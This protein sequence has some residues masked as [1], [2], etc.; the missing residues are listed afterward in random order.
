MKMKAN[1][2]AM[3]GWLNIFKEKGYISSHV[4]REI[5]KK[6]NIKKIGHYGT[7]DPLASGVLPLALGEATKTIK[8]ITYD[9]KEY[10]FFINWGK[11]T[12][13]C[14]KEGKVIQETNIRPKID[15]IKLTI[16]KYFMGNV[17]QTPPIFSAVKVDGKRAYQL[18]R[19]NLQF[20]IKSKNIKIF[21]FELLKIVNK[22]KAEFIVDC[23]PGTYIRSLARDLSKKLGTLG[24]ASNIVRLK[25][26]YFC[27]SNSVNYDKVITFEKSNFYNKLFPVD[28]VLKN[29]EEIKLEKKYS[30][31][32][33]SGKIVFLSKYNNNE[34]RDKVFLIKYKTELVSIANLKKG[35]IIP[36]RNFN[37]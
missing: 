28:Y 7:L 5:K 35:Y 25:N 2:L 20:E 11:E 29:I 1:N 4:V 27:V 26:S 32:L 37:N 30:D 6:F 33:K 24:Y 17:D 9:R 19:K 3:N 12:D 31:M 36:R 22:D 34:E 8:F 13:T 21:K 23:G 18:A 16:K 15:E 10:S 14:D